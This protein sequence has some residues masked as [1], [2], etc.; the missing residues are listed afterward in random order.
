MCFW[1]LLVPWLGAALVAQTGRPT[2]ALESAEARLV[3]D[4]AG[5]S[6]VDFQLKKD[7]LNPFAWEEKGGATSPRPRGH[8]LCLDRW[9]APSAAELKNGVPF[10]GEAARVVWR[11][12]TQSPEQVEMETKLPLAGLTIRR[13][14]RLVNAVVV[15]QETVT[16]TNPLGRIYNMVQHPTI[17]PPFLDESTVVDANARKGFMQSS[18]MPNPEEPA[19]WWPQALK[20]G[21]PVNLRGLRDDPMPNVVSYVIDEQVGWTTAVN[22]GRGLLLGY[23]W[24]TSDYPWFNAWRHVGNG[25]PLA[26]GL[27]FGTTGL[28]QPFPILVQKGVIFGRRLYAYLDA[29]ESVTRSY[30]LF[31]TTVPND[32]SGVTQV[33]FRGQRIAIQPRRGDTHWIEVG[34]IMTNVFRE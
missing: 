15:V 4:L 11:V 5:G 6:L 22:P 27:E 32:Y 28:H 34:G 19:V 10:H 23:L 13:T 20:D 2:V 17:G 9:G 30:C 16:N 3:L 25:K 33:S 7:G 8:F 1:K 29:S 14:V 26:R 31:L 21:E 24:K 18:P 12:I